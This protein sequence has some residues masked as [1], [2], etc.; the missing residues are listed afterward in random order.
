M[1]TYLVPTD[2][3]EEANQA[4]DF[5]IDMASHTGATIELLHVL[6]VPYGSYNVVGEV[7]HQY[8]AE[9]LYE[10]ML[11]RSTKD[12]LTETVGY[13][14]D[15][16]LTANSTLEFGSPY[17]HIQSHITGKDCNLVIMGSKGASGLE[18]LLIGSNAERVIRN[19]KCPVITVKGPCSFRDISEMV[20]ATDATPEH[21]V[22]V[23]TVKELQDLFGWKINLLRVVTPRNFLT[24]G[25]AKEQLEAFTEKYG[26]KNFTTNVDEAEFA[27]EGIV[28]FAEK[29][30][31][32]LIV[33]GTK[34]RTGLAHI[35]G[36]SKAEDVANESNIPVLTVRLPEE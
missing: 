14:E 3:S 5:A 19:A 31:M 36:G 24:K 26:F 16:G 25:K 30:H 13:V 35:F 11:V 9:N 8:K 15:K 34:G 10:A 21:Y 12:K 18:E 6:E 22:V 1:K 29:K 32:G 7:N 33:M 20:Y 17:R 4:L 23:K 28:N 27:D 2:F